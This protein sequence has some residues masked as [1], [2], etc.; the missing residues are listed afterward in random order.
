MTPPK[1]VGVGA[2]L[3]TARTERNVTLEQASG[4]TRI[5][6]R[7][8]V[9]LEREEAS[10]LPPYVY[11]VGLLRNYARFLG[12]DPGNAVAQW[13]QERGA[14]APTSTSPSARTRR[15]LEARQW[16]VDR[17]RAVTRGTLTQRLVGYGGAGV[18]MAIA[19]LFIALQL[20]RFAAPPPL[21]VN[22]PPNES[23]TLQQGNVSATVSGT[24]RANV[25]IRVT[26]GGGAV[27]TTTADGGGAWSI[28]IPLAIGA[29]QVTIRAEDPATGTTSSEPVQRVFIVPRRVG[30][31]PRLDLAAPAADAVIESKD[32]PLSL[33]S[34]PGTPVTVTATPATGGVAVIVR[35]VADADGKASGALSLPS[36]SWIINATAGVPGATQNQVSRQVRVHYTGVVVTLRGTGATTWV[37]A[38][39]DGVVDVGVGATGRTLRAGDT[40]TLTGSRMVEIRFG[41]APDITV[42]L[43]G[44][45]LT[46]LGG[47]GVPTTWQFAADGSVKLSARK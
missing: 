40:I 19:G 11:T 17:A 15:T 4:A 43:N 38:W 34:D 14:T 9:A 35:L 29:N 3:R 39:I 42:T 20:L 28:D 36:G 33:T 13:P 22:V 41:S 24:S 26:T 6:L 8:L 47:A 10:G 7:I 44:R 31:A 25:R 18:L 45:I 37:R 12:I 32:V 21:T 27:L 46:P 23:T 30:A 16:Y 1:P 2:L 5:P